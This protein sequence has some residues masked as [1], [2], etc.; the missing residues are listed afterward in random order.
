MGHLEALAESW[1]KTDAPDTRAR[2]E[3]KCRKCALAHVTALG[4]RLAPQSQTPV[5]QVDVDLPDE[6]VARFASLS[7]REVEVVTL[8]ASGHTLESAGRVLF[9]T[10]NTV[11]SHR[12][13]IY[14]KLDIGSAIQLGVIAAKAGLV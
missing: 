4:A 14:K 11:K 2:L 3:T 5:T 7:D 9:L 13:R 10:A 12:C 1:R 6:D 8:L